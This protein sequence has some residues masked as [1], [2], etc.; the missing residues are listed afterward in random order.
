MVDFLFA[1]KAGVTRRALAEVAAFGVVG[2][3]PGVETGPVRAT[4]GAQL[5]VVA[6]KTRRAG[7]LVSAFVVLGSKSGLRG[8]DSG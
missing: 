5:A 2:A 7:A 3:T 4:V 8:G 1:V 6:V